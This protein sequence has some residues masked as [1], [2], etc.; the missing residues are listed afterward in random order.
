MNSLEFKELQSETADLIIQYDHFDKVSFM[1]D[2]QYSMQYAEQLDK[3]FILSKENEL[4]QS[5]LLMVS[6]GKSTVE[7]NAYILA[8][9]V[10]TQNELK[11][12]QNKRN[13]GFEVFNRINEMTEEQYYNMVQLYEN[14]IKNYH[15]GIKMNATEA[16][17]L[18]YKQA[19]DY[20]KTSNYIALN[21]L[22]GRLP[23][24]QKVNISEAEYNKAN[25]YYHKIK[26]TIAND[27]KN[28]KDKYP[29]DKKSVF[30]NEMTELA[31]KFD[32]EENIKQITILNEALH[33]DYVA[34]MREDVKL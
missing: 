5:V 15:P 13:L 28:R 2:L 9:K 20:F 31:E 24:S 3:G 4:M 8:F 32:L 25:A 11:N 30:A 18:I 23:E 17:N 10:Q 34:V 29:F 22:I 12:M 26:L 19:R 14:Y 16:D 1:L 21:S 7:I 27:I 6:G 33:K